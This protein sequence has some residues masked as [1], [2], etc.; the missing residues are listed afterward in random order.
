MKERNFDSVLLGN[1]V[2]LRATQHKHLGLNLDR[3]LAF[4]DHITSIIV[5]CNT[6][7]NP[8]KSLKY[9]IRSKHLERIY[10]SFILPHLEYCSILLDSANAD[11]LFKLEQIHYRAALVVSGCSL[12]T[13]KCKVYRCLGWMSLSERRKEKK[14]IFMYDVISHNVPNYVHQAVVSFSNPVNDNRLRNSRDFRLPHNMSRR[15][16]KSSIPSAIV[17]WENL[18][19]E[20]KNKFSRNSFK[21]N[22]R[23]TFN[24]T[25]SLFLTSNADLSRKEEIVLNKIKCDVFSKA[26]LFAHQWP[27]IS[28]PH[29]NCGSQSQT[30]KHI[31]FSC[32][33]LHNER[34][35]F[36][37]CMSLLPN[38]NLALLHL[39]RQDE[40][41]QFILFLN[42]YIPLTEGRRALKLLTTF[43]AKIVI[44]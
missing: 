38:V 16:A 27:H 30:V 41:M 22:Y 32:P 40:R 9:T 5:K 37:R 43:F 18:P 13:S 44:T 35:E 25:K 10:F 19:R 6:L 1:L 29:C 31:L 42:N 3:H 24:G 20:L 7:L 4:R 26:Q 15:F 17:E 2:I 33:L 12:G 36:L 23:L 21:Y 28:N 11:L 39:A 14:C 8:L 34:E